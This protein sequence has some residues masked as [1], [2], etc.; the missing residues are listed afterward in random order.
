MCLCAQ[1][2][3]FAPAALFLSVSARQPLSAGAE[4]WTNPTLNKYK[5][6]TMK[7]HKKPMVKIEITL[8]PSDHLDFENLRGSITP[9]CIRLILEEFGLRPCM[10]SVSEILPRSQNTTRS[11]GRKPKITLADSIRALERSSQLDYKRNQCTSSYDVFA[12]DF[13][14]LFLRR[15]KTRR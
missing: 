4:S 14:D 10:T 1:L 9:I 6:S 13:P 12:R 11:D 5:Y 15:Q 8:D 7:D 2:C 3:F